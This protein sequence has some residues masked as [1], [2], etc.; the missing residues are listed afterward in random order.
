MG[1]LYYIIPRQDP[2]SGPYYLF[3]REPPENSPF[4]QFSPLVPPEF[5]FC[6]KN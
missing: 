2:D 4:P 6:N 5:S 1:P 3:L